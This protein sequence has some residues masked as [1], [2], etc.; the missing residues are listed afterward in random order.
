V[1][2]DRA[3]EQLAGMYARA[4]RLADGGRSDRD[5]ALE[6]GIDEAAVAPLLRIG[7]AKLAHLMAEMANGA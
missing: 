6:L 2:R 1:E 5:I 4:L 7:G 3:L